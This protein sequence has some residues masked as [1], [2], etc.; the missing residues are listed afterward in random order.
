[1]TVVVVVVLLWVWVGVVGC[2][3]GSGFVGVGVVVVVV[4]VGGGNCERQPNP[5]Q[6]RW[7]ILTKQVSPIFRKS[8]VDGWTKRASQPAHDG[9]CELSTTPQCRT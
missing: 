1:L 3:C 9:G 8:N 4:V 5:R 7:L 2:G 6:S